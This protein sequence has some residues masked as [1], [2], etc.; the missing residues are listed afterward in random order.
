MRFVKIPFLPKSSL[1]HMH[2]Y[3]L[4]K[5]GGPRVS[6]EPCVCVCVWR[7]SLHV[8]HA[9]RGVTE[10]MGAKWTGPPALTFFYHVPKT[11]GTGL[12]DWYRRSLSRPV[13]ERPVDVV[14]GYG[15]SRCFMVTQFSKLIDTATS[16]KLCRGRVANQTL[17]N[18]TRSVG[19]G[20]CHV[21]HG[22]RAYHELPRAAMER[23]RSARLLP[24][25]VVV[26]LHSNSAFWFLEHILPQ[27]PKL[28][29]FYASHGGTCTTVTLIR[30]PWD[31]VFSTYHMWPPSLNP[32]AE[33]ECLA[34][35]Q[36]RRADG[37]DGRTHSCQSPQ[38]LPFPEYARN[39]DGL[40]LGKHQCLHRGPWR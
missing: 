10:G 24:S 15:F 19:K 22:H 1:T 20:S 14:V 29:A 11:G 16:T 34:T 28:R 12:M 25:R 17:T 9:R 21:A 13:H 32:V 33:R 39:V 6:L 27:V 3:E 18:C 35:N 36:R 23:Q 2:V 7:L 5:E 37:E 8:T 40:L 26:E 4:N 31:L 38:R 30:E